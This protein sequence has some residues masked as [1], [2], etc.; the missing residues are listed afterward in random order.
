MRW[1]AYE[2]GVMDMDVHA[3]HR[4]YLK[5]FAGRG[6]KLVCD[7]PVTRIERRDGLWRI[8]AGSDSITHPLSSTRPAPGPIASPPSPAYRRWDCSPSG[9]PR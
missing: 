8:E 5:G 9:A 4:G 3:I 1:A 7:A 2:P 6:G